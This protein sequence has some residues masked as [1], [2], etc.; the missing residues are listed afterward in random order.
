MSRFGSCDVM[1]IEQETV[2]ENVENYGKLM[3]RI[4]TKGAIEY[5]CS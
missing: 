4:E 3:Q 1:V 5:P 2:C